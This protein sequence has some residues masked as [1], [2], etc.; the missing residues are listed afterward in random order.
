MC[1]CVC[2]RIM[3]V[4]VGVR[5]SNECAKFMVCVAEK[6]SHLWRICAAAGYEGSTKAVLR[7]Y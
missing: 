6:F 4:S 7:L 1:V 2:V 3:R 5:V